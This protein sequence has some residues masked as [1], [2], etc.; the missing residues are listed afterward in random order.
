MSELSNRV[1]SN[2]LAF[3]TALEFLPQAIKIKDGKLKCLSPLSGHYRPST[4]NF[5]RFMHSLVEEGVDMSSVTISKSYTVL[6]GVEAY[7]KLKKGK[8]KTK[9]VSKNA[10]NGVATHTNMGNGVP[11][12]HRVDV[13]DIPNCEKD[14]AIDGRRR[15]E[16]RGHNLQY[17]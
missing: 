2:T 12:P 9:E 14:I 5:K 10:I 16:N 11:E 3:C 4:E 6:L 1:P 15:K 7:A 8:K 17:P 13:V